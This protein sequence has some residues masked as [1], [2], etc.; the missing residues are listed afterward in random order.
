MSNLE[1]GKSS[2]IRKPLLIHYSSFIKKHWFPI[3]NERVIILMMGAM[4]IS[5][6]QASILNRE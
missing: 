1:L 4:P 6:E 5:I 3:G 2:H